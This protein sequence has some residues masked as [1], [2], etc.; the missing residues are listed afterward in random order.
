MLALWPEGRALPRKWQRFGVRLTTVAEL[1]PG[2][3]VFM[4]LPN[5]P[6]FTALRSVAYGAHGLTIRTDYG[7][8]GAVAGNRVLVRTFAERVA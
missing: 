5:G 8:C 3:S 6:G 4:R 2:A 1:V 7:D